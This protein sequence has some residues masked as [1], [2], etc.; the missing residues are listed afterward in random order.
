MSLSS[1]STFV[2]VEAEY[3]NTASYRIN[4]STSEALRHAVAI[5]FLLLLLP[6]TST[7]GANTVGY[8]M[9]LLQDQLRAANDYAEAIDGKP[10]RKNNM[11][12]ADFRGM[13]RFG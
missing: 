2:Q 11:V 9:S 12:R 7:K 6:S 8:S 4:A 5:G 13:R 1:S 3:K 10:T